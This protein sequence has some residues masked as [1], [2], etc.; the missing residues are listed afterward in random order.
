MTAGECHADEDGRVTETSSVLV[1]ARCCSNH[2]HFCTRVLMGGNASL[3][4]ACPARRPYYPWGR[5]GCGLADVFRHWTMLCSCPLAAQRE[6]PVFTLNA[7][8]PVRYADRGF[9]R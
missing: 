3:L 7:R 5:D 6:H 4:K 9:A 2:F 1:L 8:C